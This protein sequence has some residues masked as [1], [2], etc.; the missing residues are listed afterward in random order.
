MGLEMLKAPKETD[1]AAYDHS[2]TMCFGNLRH[3]ESTEMTCRTASS[4]FTV[5]V[6][7][8]FGEFLLLKQTMFL[9]K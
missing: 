9:E 3:E 4:G 1:L 7:I 2:S 5:H 6:C 8:S